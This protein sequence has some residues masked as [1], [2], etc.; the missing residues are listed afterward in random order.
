MSS[1]HI[2]FNTE[3]EWHALE[4]E[5]FLSRVGLQYHWMNRDYGTF[6]D[7]LGALKQSKRKSIRQVR[8]IVHCTVRKILLCTHAKASM[9]PIQSKHFHNSW[10]LA[11]QERKS[12]AASGLV[13]QRL[14]GNEITPLIWDKFYRFYRNTTGMRPNDL[15]LT[16]HCPFFCL[17]LR[18]AGMTLALPRTDAKWGQAYLTRDFFHRLGET[19]VRCV[20]FL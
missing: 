16:P 7:F 5:G 17:L 4:S 10:P 3:A 20:S 14:S 12:V 6:E 2:T 15:A 19:M 8:P 13:L 18:R 9:H 11:W 1:L